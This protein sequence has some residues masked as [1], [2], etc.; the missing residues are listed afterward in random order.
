V[1]FS[2][3]RSLS[4]GA[5]VLTARLRSVW[6]VES[7]FR[8]LATDSRAKILGNDETKMCPCGYYIQNAR[9]D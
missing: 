2:L 9:N 8:L 7:D 4:L 5:T 1:T 3:C 6:A